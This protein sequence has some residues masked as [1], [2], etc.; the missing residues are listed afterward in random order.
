MN[1]PVGEWVRLGLFTPLIVRVVSYQHE[2]PTE[3]EIGMPR[4]ICTECGNAVADIDPAAP[5]SESNAHV[6]MMH[7]PNDE[8]EPDVVVCG[9]C[10]AGIVHL[11]L[12]RAGRLR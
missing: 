4:R 6:F 8:A 7:T 5:A 3:T 9:N 12:A 10:A 1:R 11:H 2:D